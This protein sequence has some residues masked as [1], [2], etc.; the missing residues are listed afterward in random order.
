[1]LVKPRIH[2]NSYYFGWTI[3]AFIA[4]FLLVVAFSIRNLSSVRRLF[5][6]SITSEM[7]SANYEEMKIRYSYF[8]HHQSP[9]L[10]DFSSLSPAEDGTVEGSR[11]GTFTARLSS[12]FQSLMDPDFEVF[13]SL[14][15]A[16]LKAKDIY[17]PYRLELVKEDFPSP[18]KT[19]VSGS[20]CNH[21]PL[22]SS[23]EIPT[24]P[25]S[26]MYYR[27]TFSAL[28]VFLKQNGPLLFLEVLMLLILSFAMYHFHMLVASKKETK[29]LN[30]EFLHMVT[31]NMNNPIAIALASAETLR[32]LPCPSR[33]P[34]RLAYINVIISQL[35]RLSGE[36]KSVLLNSNGI[37]DAADFMELN[38]AFAVG[39]VSDQMRI[40]NPKAKID[41]DIPEDVVI[42]ADPVI[43]DEILFNLIE[44]AIKYSD[45]DPCV[46][47]TYHEDNGI[48]SLSIADKGRGIASEEIDKIFK[49]YYKVEEMSLTPGYGLGLS[50]VKQAVDLHGWDI[51]VESKL[52]EGSVF[53]IL[54]NL[55]KEQCKKVS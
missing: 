29:A 9:A 7:V 46:S 13:D 24:S 2:N 1:M 35:K 8:W 50:F 19:S 31:H 30:E 21:A 52:G 34:K 20:F 36:V 42:K 17:T 37:H 49:K 41:L 51:D 4:I 43:F 26:G 25:D 22:K 10:D 54:F 47:I 18:I 55:N 33:D 15:T 32:S 6:D 44:N 53:T 3:V 45:G 16:S 5:D 23:I 11:E 48:P 39:S 38:L 14:F 27:C 40:P 12:L 28:P